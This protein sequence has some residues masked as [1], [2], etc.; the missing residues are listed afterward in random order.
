MGDNK[1]NIIRWL[2]DSAYRYLNIQQTTQ[3]NAEQGVNK[4]IA[5]PFYTE[6]TEQAS[7]REREGDSRTRRLLFG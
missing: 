6:E 3:P 1:R 5:F 4:V 2:P 7:K